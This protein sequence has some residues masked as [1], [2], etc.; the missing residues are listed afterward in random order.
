MS[1][2]VQP[3]VASSTFAYSSFDPPSGSTTCSPLDDLSGGGFVHDDYSYGYDHHGRAGGA[4]GGEGGGGGYDYEQFGESPRIG[5]D[6][7]LR[8]VDHAG[9]TSGRR[10]TRNDSIFSFASL[11][12]SRTPRADNV[13]AAGDGDGAGGAFQGEEYTNHAFAQPRRDDRG[14]RRN[15]RYGLSD[16]DTSLVSEHSSASHAYDS[17]SDSDDDD[18]L[19][20]DLR[21]F[22]GRDSVATLNSRRQQD[23]A[24]QEGRRHRFERLT[25]Q[26]LS[27]MGVSTAL[28]VTL[29]TG[30]VVLAFVG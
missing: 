22:D 18:D 17:D 13:H 15:K 20:E 29:T 10:A 11:D 2:R 27:W 5:P 14:G 26:E 6:P 4:T 9:S 25:R 1:H 21:V 7:S 30:A 12:A 24:S 8:S 23:G 19:R 16:Q 28:V 3:S